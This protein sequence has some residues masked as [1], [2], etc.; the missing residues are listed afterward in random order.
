MP[1]AHPYKPVFNGGEFSPR[2][3]ARTDFDRYRTGLAL[4]ENLL[5]LPEGGLMR[6]SGSRY[7]AGHKNHDVKG[8]LIPFQFSTLQAYQ[9]EFGGT[10]GVGS[11]TSIRFYRFQAQ[12]IAQDTDAAIA[13]GTF[14]L[15]ITD[16]DDRSTGA[17]AI[18]HDATNARLSLTPGG[19]TAADIG[20]AEQD[21]A[22]DAA[23][24]A[25]VHVIKF[26]VI[27]APGDKVEFQVGTTTTGAEAL[28]AVEKEVGYHCVEFTPG[29][30]TF[31]VQFRNLGTNAN[32]V[33]QIDNVSIIDD[34]P[35]EVDTPYDEADFF[36]LR[37]PQSADVRYFFHQTYPTYK[38]ERRGHR[39]W[40]LVE[41]AWQDG[42]WME[43]NAT[44]TTLTFASATGLG[45]SVTASSIKGI[46][47][48]EGFKTTDVGR[49]IRLT[50][51]TANWGW[52]V[53]V[54]WTSTTVV[55]VDIKRTVVT[56]VAQTTWRLG[57][58]SGTT[59]YPRAGTFYQQRMFAGGTTDDP[60]TLDASNT[61]D[62]ENM[63]PDSLAGAVYDETVE[64]DD[65]FR[66]TIDA[67]GVNAI[68]WISPGKKTL[69]IGTS[70][71]EWSVSSVG[72]V[73][74]PSDVVVE[75]ET[76]HGSASV[77]PVRVGNVVLFLQR[78][79]RKLREFSFSF[80]DDGFRAP[81]LTR[82]AS[83]ITL[84]GI[85]DMAYAEEPDSVLW[86][87]RA[88]GQLLSMTYRRE[89]SVVGWVRHILGG[90]FSG[91]DAVVE[92]VSVIPGASTTITEATAAANGLGGAQT[93]NSTDR[94]EVWVTV[95]RTINGATKR[96]TEVFERDF[97]TGD[98]QEDAYYCDS[99]ITYDDVATT[100]MTG[101]DHL[102]GETVA[103]WADGAVQTSQ[104]VTA[105]AITLDETASV[106]QMGLAYTH[107]FDTLKMD[108]GNPAGTAIGKT[109][110]IPEVAF[111]VL[112]TMFLKFGSSTTT[113][114][115]HDVRS[116]SDPMDAAAPLYTGEKV[117]EFGENETDEDVR[118]V[119]QD[120][121][122][123]P[124]TL[125]SLAPEVQVN[126]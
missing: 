97:E 120:S 59:G 32:K 109:K 26:Q 38:L 99:L 31:Y 117:Y 81:N 91:G 52:A 61:S 5:P 51:A 111:A 27:G 115:D 20:W 10:L 96:Y 29:A 116:V 19:A 23:N 1:V 70:G 87:V 67:E 35:V 2:I 73:I 112:N 103:I 98:A 39:T 12:I 101:L 65:S 107:R 15:G 77:D 60:Q 83:H 124:F 69:V 9:L 74:T 121:R 34:N 57:A 76:S 7:V 8:R 119:M 13:N 48:N 58:W 22:V 123:A 64:D 6:R 18:S 106:V 105:G 88:D 42:P 108:V 122:P 53:I 62:F 3:L 100:A 46:N 41:V 92:S 24:Q 110:S 36:G 94:N 75:P 11:L 113:L 82:L 68:E 79:L 118:I 84:G 49:L 33:V 40:S 86:A 28:A 25:N 56:T 21:V 93:Q 17:G 72:A 47:S 90:S 43:K 95:K 4:C 114:E 14:T 71:G 85:T 125:L 63:A 104:V 102:E 66:Y 89:E 80:D 55:T 54:G 16:W 45:V 30:T 44:A 78:A 126:A 37:G 50:A